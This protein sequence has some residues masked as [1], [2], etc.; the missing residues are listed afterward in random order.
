MPCLIEAH[1]DS[2]GNA[3]AGQDN[4][5]GTTQ[6]QGDELLQLRSDMTDSEVVAMFRDGCHASGPVSGD[7]ITTSLKLVGQ[8]EMTIDYAGC[9]F[10]HSASATVEFWVRTL[11]LETKPWI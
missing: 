1:V 8:R 9:M 6:I 11:L 4:L 10:V 5:R 7:K 2:Q 3:I